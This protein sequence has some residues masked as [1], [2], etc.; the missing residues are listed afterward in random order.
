MPLPIL[1]IFKTKKKRA[2][3]ID[4]LRASQ[5]SPNLS[6]CTTDTISS[7]AGRDDSFFAGYLQTVCFSLYIC[8]CI[9]IYLSLPLSFSLS[10]M[11]S[12]S[13]THTLSLF[14]S[15]RLSPSLYITLFLQLATP[16]ALS[17]SY[18]ID[19]QLSLTISFISSFLEGLFFIA[20]KL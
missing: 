14:L 8:V 15:L 11:L 18:F 1:H 17:L 16:F 9:Y 5:P 10:A 2:A 19:D 3:E 12:L 7:S 6:V 13:L 20:T 4:N